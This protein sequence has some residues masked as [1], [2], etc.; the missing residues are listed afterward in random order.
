MEE[1]Y[2]R[3]TVLGLTIAEIFILLVFLMLLALMGMN[4]YWN[5]KLDP[6]KEIMAKYAPEKVKEELKLPEQLRS[7]IEELE[8]RK[9]AL[10]RRVRVLEGEKRGLEEKLAEADRK[11]GEA[12]RALAEREETLEDAERKIE[13]LEKLKR[14]IEELEKRKEALQRR[15]RVLEGEKRGLEEKLAE[16]DRKHGEAMR[17]LAEREETL[18][19]AE[20]KIETLTIENDELRSANSALQDENVTLG[21]RIRIIGKGPTPPCW[22]QRVEETNPITKADWREK[23]YYLFDIAIH[24]DHME[25]QRLAIP[26]GSAEDD[27]GTPYAEENE[28]LALDRIDELYGKP[29]SDEDVLVAMQPLHDQGKASDIRTYS[30]IFYVRVWDETHS[31]AKKRWKQA[32]DE[33][34]EQ[35]FGTYQVRGASWEDRH[36]EPVNV[37][38]SGRRGFR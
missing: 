38:I 34:L 17:A 30:C 35:L 9:E 24:D 1:G 28:K 5:D 7:E 11:H 3:G 31:G 19:D 26:R 23:P 8:K 12:M 18:E 20:R 4:R 36:E 14:Q 6:W 32:H 13:E 2:R 22:Y 21:E 27:G 25:V 37:P 15:V 29:L 33:V 10:Q 16:A